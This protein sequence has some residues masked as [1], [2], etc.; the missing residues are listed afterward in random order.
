MY[1]ATC[2]A[3]RSERVND[4]L[5]GTKYICPKAT[6]WDP[7]VA[8]VAV[9]GTEMMGWLRFQVHLQTCVNVP[10]RKIPWPGF[11][12]PWRVGI[13]R[14][15]S[16]GI[17]VAVLFCLARTHP[18]VADAIAA[19]LILYTLA[20]NTATVFVSRRP[21]DAFR[22][23][24]L[25]LESFGELVLAFAV[26]YLSLPPAEFCLPVAT[27]VRAIY[28]STVTFATVGF[29][30]IRPADAALVAPLMVTGQ[31]FIGLYFLA[32]ILTNVVSFASGAPRPLT[33]NEVI[34]QSNRLDQCPPAA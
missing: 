21:R 17:L 26:I 27:P 19:V 24:V 32:V 34:D 33:L 9:P 5:G 23:T 6:F 7:H 4:L 10:Y 3:S 13:V 12:A 22:A 30:D 15:A 16:I 28:F 20:T 8:C 29:G 18:V 1:C 31:I 14:L 11:L 25:A 2:D